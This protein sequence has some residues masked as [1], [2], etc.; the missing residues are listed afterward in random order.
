MTL[1]GRSDGVQDGLE[2]NLRALSRAPYDSGPVGAL[3]AFF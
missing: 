1:D 2:R 3:A